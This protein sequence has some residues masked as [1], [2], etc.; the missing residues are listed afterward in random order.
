MVY[1]GNYTFGLIANLLSLIFHKIYVIIIDF[2][3]CEFLNLTFKY[4]SL[5][6]QYDEKCHFDK[7]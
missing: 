6:N 3:F 2:I 4:Y 7:L 1:T 5:T